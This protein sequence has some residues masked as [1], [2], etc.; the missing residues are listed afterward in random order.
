MRYLPVSLLRQS[1][2][3]FSSD[4]APLLG[5]LALHLSGLGRDYILIFQ[6]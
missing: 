4:F 1:L 6:D 3:W 5:M 2:R